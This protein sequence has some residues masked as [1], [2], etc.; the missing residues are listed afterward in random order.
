MG[1]EGVQRTKIIDSEEGMDDIYRSAVKPPEITPG[2]AS[3]SKGSQAHRHPH[4]RVFRE[5]FKLKSTLLPHHK[6]CHYSR[7]TAF[8]CVLNV[9]LPTVVGE[10]IMIE[11]FRIP[12]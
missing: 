7:S 4:T 3:S 5:A 8:I 12:R 9:H 2:L 10:N 11:E 6:T 1:K